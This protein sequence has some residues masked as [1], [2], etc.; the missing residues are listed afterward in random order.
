MGLGQESPRE[1]KIKSVFTPACYILSAHGHT[2]F[3][4]IE[5]NIPKMTLRIDKE[6]NIKKVGIGGK[7]Q[8]G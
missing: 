1:T 6:N 7:Y 3:S 4:K 8:K 2:F 5:V